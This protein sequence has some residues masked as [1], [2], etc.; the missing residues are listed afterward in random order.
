MSVGNG[1]SVLIFF[2]CFLSHALAPPILLLA[3]RGA[4]MKERLTTRA[5]AFGSAYKP[6]PGFISRLL[7]DTALADDILEVYGRAAPTQTNLHPSSPLP[8]TKNAL[9]PIRQF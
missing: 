4:Q 2:C 6:S 3:W 7:A 5:T 8:P 9:P 1:R